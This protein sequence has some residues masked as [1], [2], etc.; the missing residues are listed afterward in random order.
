MGQRVLAHVRMG[1]IPRS[2]KPVPC[3]P[4]MRLGDYSAR[5]TPDSWVQELAYRR[6]LLQAV[7]VG[8]APGAEEAVKARG[9]RAAAALW[10][11]YRVRLV[12]IVSACGRT[13]SPSCSGPHQT[14]SS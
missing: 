14:A 9:A 6:G 10:R 12:P 13:G 4:G 3:G 11:V 5:M 2:P 7:K 8:W 1:I